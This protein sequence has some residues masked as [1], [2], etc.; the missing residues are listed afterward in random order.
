LAKILSSLSSSS[1]IVSTYKNSVG[2]E[3]YIINVLDQEFYSTL[4]VP[5]PLSKRV[6]RKRVW[7]KAEQ[8]QEPIPIPQPE[9]I[10]VEEEPDAMS[11]L[12]PTLQNE[13]I[14]VEEEP[15]QEEEEDAF[16]ILF[17]SEPKHE[18]EELVQEQDAIA[19][20][21]GHK[22]EPQEGTK[23]IIQNNLRRFTSLLDIWV[24]GEPLPEIPDREEVKVNITTHSRWH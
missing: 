4:Q 20:L 19:V 11:I 13:L 3:F 22:E 7:P 15:K 8:D 9:V 5:K 10:N 24:A 6:G 17:P 14:N 12:F 1:Y 18:K 23:D 16:S 2:E 21:F